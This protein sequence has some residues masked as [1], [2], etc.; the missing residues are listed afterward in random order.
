MQRRCVK[1]AF[2]QQVGRAPA[3]PTPGTRPAQ[4]S[5]GNPGAVVP[6]TPLFAARE[7]AGAVVIGGWGPGAACG[8]VPRPQAVI[9]GLPPRRRP[10]ASGPAPLP[11]S[12]PATAHRRATAPSSSAPTEHGPDDPRR[13]WQR[14]PVEPPPPPR[15]PSRRDLH[16]STTPQRDRGSRPPEP[17][18]TRRRTTRT[19]PRR[20][21]S[22]R[23]P[24]RDGS[25]EARLS[26]RVPPPRRTARPAIT[27]ARRGSGGESV[28]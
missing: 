17:R 10:R 20:P 25:G 27:A 14:A 15:P 7:P 19:P 11:P 16:H 2:L 13:T 9:T 24:S 21:G 22:G 1:G 12:T 23:F 8:P 18:E 26:A 4:A 3:P 6:F 28:Q 5:A